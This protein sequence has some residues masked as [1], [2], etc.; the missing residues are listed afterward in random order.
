MWIHSESINCSYFSADI[1][2][3]FL[4]LEGFFAVLCALFTAIS[5]C[6]G[7][8]AGP[9]PRQAETAAVRNFTSPCHAQTAWLRGPQSARYRRR[10][11]LLQ[12]S[13][14]AVRVPDSCNRRGRIRQPFGLR[15]TRHSRASLCRGFTP[16]GRGT[17]RTAA[18]ECVAFHTACH[19]AVGP[20]PKSSCFFSFLA[21]VS[22]CFSPP[23]Q[24]P[25]MTDFARSASSL[26]TSLKEKTHFKALYGH[27]NISV[28][29]CVIKYNK[30]Q[31]MAFICVL[32]LLFIAAIFRLKKYPLFCAHWIGV[33]PCIVENCPDDLPRG[34]V[35]NIFSPGNTNFWCTHTSL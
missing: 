24:G 14:S 27:K 29:S 16:D 5:A 19:P 10:H 12:A 22:T 13:A 17:W 31:Q 34:Y 28:N 30:T 21:G 6:E 2:V 32:R 25:V 1:P 3:I 35:K 26:K 15:G 23:L 33:F 9:C 11:R 8:A 20:R 4:R 7:R 18:T